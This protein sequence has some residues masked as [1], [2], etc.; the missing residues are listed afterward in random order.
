[1]AEPRPEHSAEYALQDR[2]PAIMG[3]MVSLTA[4][5]TIFVAARL[6]VR[7]RLLRN[8]GLDDYLITASLVRDI[9]LLIRIDVSLTSNASKGLHDHQHPVQRPCNSERLRTSL[10]YPESGAAAKCGEMD[11]GSL[12]SRR[13]LVRPAKTRCRCFVEEAH[14]ARPATPDLL[15]GFVD[16]G[17]RDPPHQHRDSVRAMRSAVVFLD[18]L[19]SARMLESM[20]VGSLL[21]CWLRSVQGGWKSEIIRLTPYSPICRYGLV[22]CSVSGIRARAP[23]DSTRQE[24]RVDCCPEYRHGRNGCRRIQVHEAE[25]L[26]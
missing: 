3:G 9:C 10:R 7:V 23:A 20:G 25:G 24:I 16:A 22:P 1:M 12:R 17:S 4:L 19:R 15:V 14:G 2:G 21:H 18:L 5:A 11:H 6:F 8:V 13:R 26:G